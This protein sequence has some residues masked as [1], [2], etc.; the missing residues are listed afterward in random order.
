[1]I[2]IPMVLTLV[3]VSVIAG[4]TVSRT[5][6]YKALAIFG[7]AAVTTGL[8]W[9]STVGTHTTGSQLTA[10]MILVGIG[11]GFGMPIFN[12]IVQNAF[13][14][15]RLGIATASVQLFR[16]VGATIGVAVMGSVLNN[17]LAHSLGSG[18]F[19]ASQLSNVNPASIP[20]PVKNAL[21]HAISDVFL[22]GGLVVS[23]AF[24]AS[25]FLKEVP[26]RTSHE[27]PTA[28]EDGAPGASH[29]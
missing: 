28:A 3:A 11:L 17:R 29:T 5:G 22:I 14:H 27:Y 24:F 21:S 4:Q 25:W 10:R 18:H 13:P 23:I 1:V 20:A 7:M 12:L 8:L 26:L 2:L 9:L 6:R 19:S 15:S 16:S